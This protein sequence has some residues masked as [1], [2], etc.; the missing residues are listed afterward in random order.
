MDISVLDAER[1]E[2]SGTR[3]SRRLRRA[4]MA[5]AVL[6]GHGLEVVSLAVSEEAIRE[7]I[8]R[9]QRSLDLRVGGDAQRALIKDVQWDTWGREIL[10]IDFVR[11]S[12]DERVK[13]SVA[14]DFHGTPNAVSSGAMM[15]HPLI[16]VDIE[17]RVDEIPERIRVDVGE[18]EVGDVIHVSDLALPQGA[19][20]VTTAS[21]IAAVL[22]PPREAAAEEEAEEAEP[23]EGEP[24]V[25][26]R[27]AKEEEG[28]ETE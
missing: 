1:R 23:A 26:G 20:C 7:I 16:A 5:P 17:C 11:V 8:E 3:V 12:K 6:Y 10:H 18:M 15:E 25:I 28:K 19:T 9:D 4:G 21:S 2:E 13:V 14:L 22:H 27:A 24:E